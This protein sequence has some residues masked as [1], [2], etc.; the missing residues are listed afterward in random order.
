M[1]Q[2][3]LNNLEPF[4]RVGGNEK[5]RMQKKECNTIWPGEGVEVERVCVGGGE[6]SCDGEYVKSCLKYVVDPRG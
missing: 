2:H 4:G 6:R 5:I 1:N 3:S